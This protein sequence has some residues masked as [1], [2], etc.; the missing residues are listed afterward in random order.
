MTA[1]K[2][3]IHAIGEHKPVVYEYHSTLTDAHQE[4][5]RR[6]K[7]GWGFHSKPHVYTFIPPHRIQWVNVIEPDD[8]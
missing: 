8:E 5:E 1:Y 6:S 3:E 4:A 2:I 7:V